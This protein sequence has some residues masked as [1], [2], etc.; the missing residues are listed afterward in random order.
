[1]N[2]NTLHKPLTEFEQIVEKM[3]GVRQIE[4]IT[5]KSWRTCEKYCKN[6]KLFTIGDLKLIADHLGMDVCK[7]VSIAIQ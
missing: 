2:Q 7:L 4:L 6:P 3:G 1:M 5:K